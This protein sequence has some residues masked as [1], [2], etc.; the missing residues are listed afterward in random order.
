MT[1]MSRQVSP[2]SDGDYHADKQAGVAGLSW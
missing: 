2:G 1:Q